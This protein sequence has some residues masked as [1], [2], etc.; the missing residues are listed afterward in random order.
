[1]PVIPFDELHPPG[2]F[3]SAVEQLLALPPGIVISAGQASSG[4][5]TALLSLVHRAQVADQR[6]VLF[7]DQ[8]DHFLPFFPL[9]PRWDVVTVEQTP[10]AWQAAL[11]SRDGT[12]DLLVVTPLNRENAKA[13][14]A[15]AS[16]QRWI[17]VAVE[18][19]LAGLDLSYV[20]RDMGIRYADFADM[21]RWIW[22]ILLLPAIC[23]Q[24]GTEVRLDPA[25]SEL[26][27]PGQTIG[28]VKVE[29]GCTHC[30]HQGTAG[31][32]GLV[33][34]TLIDT[35]KRPIV[36]DALIRGEQITISPGLHLAAQDEARR[37]L[38]EGVI[39]L[40]TYRDA[41]QRNPLLRSQHALQ[42]VQAQADKLAKSL[43]LDLDVLTA[44]A[45]RTA[46]GVMVVDESGKVSFANALARQTIGA[47]GELT[48]VEEHLFARSPRVTR[49]LTDALNQAV[50]SKPRATRIPLPTRGSGEADIFVTPLPTA[51]GFARD[52]RRLA[53]LVVGHR[54]QVG[55]MPSQDDL[56]HLFDL[57][58]AESRVA[59]T[60]CA[61]RSPKEIARDL[62]VSVATVRSHVASLLA[63]TGTSR[64]VQLVRLLTSLPAATPRAPPLGRR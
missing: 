54:D 29:T 32:L 35:G 18:T 50:Q 24:C 16:T 22:S 49:L 25:E 27:A 39:G 37:Y 62:H 17:F 28:P 30:N 7:T 2:R 61:G 53:L 4:K 20:L 42:V 56:Q 23:D 57:T 48:I 19:P 60:L 26:L 33:D 46:T 9:P 14:L 6:V 52:T 36:R 8:R 31:H 1:M 13:V 47:P 58:P 55:A 10:A 43:W 12:D 15:A 34:I 45:E 11:A 5:V 44:L 59:L 64:Q 40:N 38:A 41:I 21:V 3:A 51:R 63:K